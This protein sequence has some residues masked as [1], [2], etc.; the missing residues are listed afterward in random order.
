MGERKPDN[1]TSTGE[2]KSVAAIGG[3]SAS[4]NFRGMNLA[5]EVI[6]LGAAS[7]KPPV[8]KTDSAKPASRDCQGS[9]IT[10]AEIAKPS[11]GNESAA[12]L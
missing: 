11:A 12:C 1:A 6:I 7:N 8:A 10:T 3:A 5:K 4:A 9:A 2:Q